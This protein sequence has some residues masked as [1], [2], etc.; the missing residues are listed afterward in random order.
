MI[1]EIMYHP[2]DLGAADNTA[3]EFLELRNITSLPVPLFDP[4]FATNTWRLRGGVDFEFPAGLELAPRQLLLVVSFDPDNDPA[5]AAAFRAKYGLGPGVRLLGPYRG[6]LDNGGESIELRRPD[7]PQ[8]NSGEAPYFVVEKIHFGDSVPW[9]AAADG[10]GSSLQRIN[11]AAYGN[12][13]ANWI[14]SPPTPGQGGNLNTPPLLAIIEDSSV[15]EFKLLSFTVAALDDDSPAQHLS[16]SLDP[17][18]PA[19]AS[20]TPQGMFRW[21]ALEIHGGHAYPI[22]IR[23]TDDGSPSVSATTTL[24]VTVNEVNRAQTFIETREKYVKAGGHLSFATAVDA[25]LPAQT[26]SFGLE[27]GAPAGAGIDPVTG[28]F[29]WSPSLAQAPGSYTVVAWVADDG[30][31]PLSAV[32]SYTVHVLEPTATL[33][34]A[35][36]LLVGNSVQLLWGA[37]PGKTYRV[38]YKNAL[39]QPAWL[40]L[41]E[42]FRVET[43]KGAA[44]YP[45]SGPTFFRI[46]QLD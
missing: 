8:T 40:P 44:A 12:D 10:K 17:G 24:T 7:A 4:N 46:L 3:D 22:T 2:P 39:D 34:V 19:G 28:V 1:S 31:P 35:D 5:L 26:L 36:V 45:R 21:R 14:A 29:T 37:T 25:D 15:D 6:K 27:D 43:G 18:S 32:Q 16:F 38:E 11:D 13:P 42:P 41:G 30:S 9:P 23:V 33:I 20:I